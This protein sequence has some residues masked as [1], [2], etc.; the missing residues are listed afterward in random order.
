MFD[1]VTGERLE[2]HKRRIAGIEERIRRNVGSDALRRRMAVILTAMRGVGFATDAEPIAEMP[3]PG[4][5]SGRQVAAL[6]GLAPYAR[7]GGKKKGKRGI[8][9]GRTRLRTVT[10]EPRSWPSGGIRFRQS[11]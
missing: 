6:A 4:P 2:L 3:E 5:I 11:S 9:G 10:A 7:A 1:D 8:V